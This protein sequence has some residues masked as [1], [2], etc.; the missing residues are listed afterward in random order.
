MNRIIDFPRAKHIFDGNKFQPALP[1][2]IK[3][4]TYLERFCC[5]RSYDIGLIQ[6]RLNDLGLAK[7]FDESVKNFSKNK[8][9]FEILSPASGEIFA[10]FEDCKTEGAYYIGCFAFTNVHS[11]DRQQIDLL[12]R[13]LLGVTEVKS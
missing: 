4:M 12:R 9:P 5:Y 8:T 3:K 10:A 11:F 6:E 13:R 2:V 1:R 7:L